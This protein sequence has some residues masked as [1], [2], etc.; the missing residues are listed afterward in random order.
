MSLA[1]INPLP[2][3]GLPPLPSELLTRFNLDPVLIAALIGI[4]ALHLW[5]FGGGA[6][7]GRASIIAGWAVAATAFIS[8]L[9]ALSVSLFAARVGQH[10]VLVLVAAP[11]IAFG[12]PLRR[13]GR[14]WPV[15]LS[16][17]VFFLSI[18]FWH[19]PI[20]YEATFSSVTWYWCMHLSL[21]G[22]AIWLWRELLNPAP[23]HAAVSLIAGALTSIQMGML[24]AFLALAGHPLFRSH[25]LTTLSWGLTPLEDQQLGGA[26]MWVPGI[27]F[28][29][30][31][32]VR[33]LMRLWASL[34]GARAT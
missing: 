5:R 8:P 4:A 12:L 33:S 22:S 13:S 19:M 28:F 30:W 10:M 1:E 31:V 9:C 34:D 26:I 6:E 21:F 23:E 25:L 11:L 18:W 29:L 15:W 17:M 20:P 32:A 3:C 2:Y 27:A 14:G 24:G 16:A 7:G